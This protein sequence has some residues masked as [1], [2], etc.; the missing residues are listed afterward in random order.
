M[1]HRLWALV[2]HTWLWLRHDLHDFDFTQEP[3]SQRQIRTWV[4][5]GVRAMEY[6]PYVQWRYHL[7]MSWVWLF[8]AVPILVLFFTFPSQWV[9]WGLLITLL[10][11]LYANWVSDFTGVHAAWAALRGD[12]LAKKTHI[13][14]ENQ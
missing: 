6:N 11:S 10:Y 8:S 5:R 1:V 12:Q 4:V 7:V 3:E 13:E 2:A 14:E 9:R